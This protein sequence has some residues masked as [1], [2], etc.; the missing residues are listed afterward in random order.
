MDLV[1]IFV[2]VGILAV[3][4]FV[5]VLQR[6]Q[7]QLKALSAAHQ[8]ALKQVQEDNERRVKR[9]E[10]AAEQAQSRAE[11]ALIRDLM[12]IADALMSA[13]DISDG[14]ATS[15]REGIRLVHR[16]FDRVLVQHGV[17]KLIPKDGDVFDPV[18]HE[19]VEQ[20]DVESGESNRIVQ[21]YRAG[22][23]QGDDVLRPAMVAVSRV[24]TELSFPEEELDTDRDEDEMYAESR[25]TAKAD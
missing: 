21:C 24:Q 7:T 6:H 11:H 20:R 15:V 4:A 12:P 13:E 25:A 19:A 8:D 14:D 22:F 9:I 5:Y 18:E 2:I 17:Q 16:E 1:W 3:V 23:R 10:R